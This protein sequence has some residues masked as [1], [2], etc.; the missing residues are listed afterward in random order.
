MKANYEKPLYKQIESLLIK[1]DD[2]TNEIKEIK[3]EHKKEVEKLN[4]KIDSLETENKVLR[5]DNDRMKKIINNDSNNSSKPPSTDIKPNKR[6]FNNREKSNKKV[7]G[8]IGH[9]G[10]GLSKIVIEEKIRT[11]KM[12]HEIIE[13]GIKNDC[14]KSKYIIDIEITAVAK[15]HRFYVDANGKY[16]IPKEYVTDVQYGEN[17]KKISTT[18]NVEEYVAIDR[19]TEFINNITE[20]SIKPTKGTVLKFI[21]ETNKKTNYIVKQIKDKILNSEIM[22]TDATVSRCNGKNQSVRNYSTE[23]TTLLVGTKGKGKKYIEETGILPQYTGT[24]IHDHETVIYNYGKNHG[25]CNV[26][27]LRYLKGNYEMTKNKWSKDMA[28]FLSCLNN[29]KK[30]KTQFNENQIKRIEKR[31][32]EIIAK[33]I[34]ENKKVKSK[35]YRIEERKL[36]RRMHKYKDNHLLFVHDFSVTFDNNISERDI[37]HVK[38]KLKIAGCFRSEK[39][40]E[41]YLNLRSIIGTCRKRKINFYEI[42]NKAYKNI[43]VEI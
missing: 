39:G 40:M 31:Y 15:E 41:K 21:E 18:L 3:K 9:E 10:K 5:E 38:S 13:H 22:Y 26:H 14:Y 36:L 20:G 1:C 27:I 4:K 24:L 23:E 6:I 34:E 32:N 33:G 25:E 2:L 28:S 29:S 17:I 37:R 11:G 42:L 35:Y 19:V 7:G 43:P 16:N 8:Q 12:K 30:E